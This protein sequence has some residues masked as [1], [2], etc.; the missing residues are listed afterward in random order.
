MRR[1][2][3]LA[4]TLVGEPRVIFLDEPTT[5]L[6]PRSRHTMWEII[7]Q[8]AA[9]GV[10]I[11]LT[12]QHLDEADQLASHIAVLER[13]RL[14]AQGTPAEL[15]RSS[16]AATSSCASSILPTSRPPPSSS[17]PTMLGGTMML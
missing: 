2:L 8:L 9:S 14:V 11:F 3:D 17:E 1:R 7:Q 6:D 13:G 10:T 4:M 15:K 12:T 5:G 16:P